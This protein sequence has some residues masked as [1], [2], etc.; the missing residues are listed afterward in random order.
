MIDQNESSVIA[1]QPQSATVTRKDISWGG[2]FAGL[3]LFLALSWLLLLL[4]A[5]LGVGIA[6]ATDLKA[7][8]DGLG[9]GSIIWIVLTSL[10]ATFAGSVLAASLAGSPDDRIG[11]LHGV[12]L[13]SA[14][15]ALIVA[16]GALGIGGAFNAMSGVVSSSASAGK[17]MLVDA[18]SEITHTS[19]IS[20]GLTTAVAA[21][22]KRQSAKLLANVA[23]GTNGPSKTEVRQ[24]INDLNTEDSSA[25][26]NSLVS[27]NT[28]AAKQRLT[29]ST[30]LSNSQ[31]DSVISG[32]EQEMKSWANTKP[33]Q[34]AEQWLNQAIAEARTSTVQAVS[35]LGGEAVSRRE[36]RQ[37]V[38]EIDAD[39][40]TQAGEYLITGSPNRAKDVMISR[41][42]LSERDIDAIIDGAEAEVDQLINDVQTQLNQVSEAA[43]TY[44]QAVLWTLFLA[45]TLGLVA[46]FLGGASGAGTVRRIYPVTETRV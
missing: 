34:Q 16:L 7:I 43:A 23:T 27:G 39:T 14:A 20:D 1:A 45:S 17:K 33:V 10:L 4:G 3:T 12:T 25:I 13:W 11:V 36:L 46:G 44:T 28:D 8:G 15:T 22:I 40:L 37:A 32:A 24:A 35:E 5:A 41:T 42:N 9:I 18:N 21:T 29:S 6:D 38:D 30:D 31:I 26:A 2:I 19:N